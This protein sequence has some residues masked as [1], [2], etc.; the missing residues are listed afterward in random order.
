[1]KKKVKSTLFLGDCLEVIK[2]FDDNSIDT[3]ITDPPYNLHFMG[4]DWDKSGVS[5]Q[6]ET[7]KSLLRVAKPGA[8]LLCFGGTRTY[9]RI[10]CAIEDGGWQIKDSLMWLYASGFPKALDISKAI[11]KHLGKERKVVG[12]PK[13]KRGRTK[14]KYSKTRRVSYDYPA[15]PVTAPAT[16]LSQEWDGWATAL[17]PAWEPIIVAMKPTDGTFAEN[18]ITHCVA[19]LNIDGSRVQYQGESDKDSATPQGKCTSKEI[20]AIGA[21]PDAGRNLER[22]EFKRAIQSGRWPANVILSHHP[23][24]K[25]V[26]L[27]KVKGTK[28][29]RVFSKVDKYGGWGNITQKHGE[30][31]N[32]YEDA[33]GYE[34]IEDWECHPDCPILLLDAQSENISHGNK[35]GGYSYRG[36]EYNVDG[37]VGKCKPQ[38]PSNYGDR[39]GASR[40]FYVTKASKKERNEGLPKGIENTHPTVKPLRLMEY[41]CTLTL[42]PYGGVVLDPFM[43]SGS[44]GVACRNINRPF[45]GIEMDEESFKISKYRI[46]RT[47]KTTDIFEDTK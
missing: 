17:K 40:F 45:I 11:D 8:F 6:A 28:P 35:K 32:K 38:A 46:R 43:G 14:Q 7:W 23:D 30:I 41:L 22:V 47:K 21:E 39:G 42:S 15:Q 27:R 4:K 5:L 1:M 44:T 16:A 36:K 2:D 19:G 20:S 12:P 10:A 18:A 9:H 13:Y 26:G 24:C 37:F 25:C 3:I 29:H 31:V 33:D 34:Q